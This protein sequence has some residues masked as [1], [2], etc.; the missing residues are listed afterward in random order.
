MTEYSKNYLKTSG[1]LWNYYRDEPNSGLEGDVDYSIKNAKSF[2]YKTSI[3]EKL[4]DNN[5][6]KQDVKIVVPLDYLSNFWRTL[7]TPSIN[8][9]VFL[10]LTWS[11]NCVLT[12]KATR[13]AD[14][15]AD[16][17][18]NEIN[19]RTNATF[20]IKDTKLY[21]P[22]V[23]LAAEND[24][25]VFEQIKTGF[26]RT[27]KWNKYRSEMSNQTEKNNFNYLVDPTFTNV[28]RLFVL[29]FE[30][31]IDR[32]TFFKYYLPKA[33]TK[34]FNVLFKGKQFFEIP[35]KNKEG[36]YEVIIEM[37]KNR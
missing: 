13:D 9:E 35:V 7:D 33:E 2:D 26:K 5:V 17:A 8:C 25:K 23:T 24:N 27:I 30:N 21:I 15:D 1:S 14:P 37:N 3:T 28:N 12:S 18:V 20:K 29:P 16:P 36:A 19:A 11:E 4:E 6:E 32:T 22:V 34:D 10:N 31:K